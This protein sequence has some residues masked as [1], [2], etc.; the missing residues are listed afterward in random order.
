[1]KSTIFKLFAGLSIFLFLSLFNTT[2]VSAQSIEANLLG[3]WD[4]TSLPIAN[5][6]NNR[7]NDIW[8]V[9]VGNVEYAVVGSCNGVHF[10]DI[11]NPAGPTEVAF[12]EGAVMGTGIIHRDYHSYQNYLYTVADEGFNSTLQVIDF[13]GLP[14]SVELVY[15]S[16]EFLSQAHNIFI[17]EENARLYTTNGQLL[18]LADPAQPTFLD[19]LGSHGLPMPNTSH[20]IFARDNILYVNGG[21]SGF[22]VVDYNDATN[23]VLLG[24]MTD[25]PQ[26]GYNHAGWLSDDGNHYYLCDETHGTDVKSITVEDFSD[27][28]VIEVFNSGSTSLDHISHNAMVRGDLLFVSYYYDGLQVFDISNPEKVFRK[29][30]Y[31]TYPDVDDDFFAG[32]WGIYSLLPSGKILLSDMQYGMHVFELPPDVGLYPSDERV[33]ACVNQQMS[34]DYLVGNDFDAAGVDLT[35]G[36]LPAGVQVTFD[37]DGISP[38]S[39]IEVSIEPLSTANTFDLEFTA[40]DGNLTTSHTI[41]VEIYEAQIEINT[42][43]P[44]NGSDDVVLTPD[45]LWLNNPGINE[46]LLE[47][48]TDSEF[49]PA[50]IVISELVSNSPY[51]PS[52]TLDH[53]TTY[54]W[55]MTAGDFCAASDVSSFTTEGPLGVNDLSKNKFLVFPNPV[56]ENIEIHLLSETSGDLKIKLMDAT[57]KVVQAWMHDSQNQISLSPKEN[58]QGLYLLTIQSEEG[59]MSKKLIIQ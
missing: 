36:N 43:S 57:G 24:S 42:G 38:G 14:N 58:L 1:M 50:S 18:S 48:S 33:S 59:M 40:T 37:G 56:E 6:I 10:I 31:D 52:V 29:F 32:A 39:I 11:D 44:A 35:V 7:Y 46:Y 22:Y 55:R 34:F 9:V 15:D 16:N 13:S 5:S 30:H 21:N 12:V 47:V 25:Y 45:F 4:D 26:Q 54:Y 41:E 53:N 2:N 23:P 3:V 51:T 28:Q 20:D 8:G 27:I 19:N 49:V 17:D